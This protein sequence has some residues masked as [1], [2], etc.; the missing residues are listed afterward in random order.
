MTNQLLL[1]TIYSHLI[2]L[3][4]VNYKR[5]LIYQSMQFSHTTVL[6]S[7]F[8]LKL[9]LICW[10]CMCTIHLD[11]YIVSVQHSTILCMLVEVELYMGVI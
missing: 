1:M 9:L 7:T 4:L 5:L 2:N 10:Y 11:V 6:L 8:L 3:L